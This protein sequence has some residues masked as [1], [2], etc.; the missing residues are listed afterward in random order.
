M[1]DPLTAVVTNVTK[2]SSDIKQIELLVQGGGILFEP[3]GHIDVLVPI[4]GRIVTRSYSQVG[5]GSDRTLQI[6]VKLMRNSSGGSRYMW[7]LDTGDQI[8]LMSARNNFPV[9]YSASSYHLL[10]GG[11]GITPIFAIARALKAARKK[12]QLLYCVSE[13]HDAAYVEHLQREF[14]SAFVLRA[15]S[16][17]GQLDAFDYLAGLEPSAELYMCGP[18]PMMQAVKAAWKNSGRPEAKLRYETFGTTGHTD[19]TEFSVTVVETGTTVIVPKDQTL[20]DSLLSAGQ[21]MMYDCR[22]GECGLCKVQIEELNG[23]IDHRDVFLS[24][25]ERC[26]AKAM[27]ACVSRI[28]AGNARIRINSISHGRPHK[29]LSAIKDIKAES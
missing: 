5:I 28:K 29:R 21:P 25:A 27:C 8:R 4:E 7:S 16:T 20:L 14:G 15:D 24:E 18:L 3:G 1:N 13:A 23:E 22:H 10:A 9:S 17:D 12:F 26:E 6:A 11:I 2:L 19:A